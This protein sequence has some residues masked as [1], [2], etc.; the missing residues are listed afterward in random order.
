MVIRRLAQLVQL[1]AVGAFVT[2]AV[3][4]FANEPTLLSA[5]ASAN[6]EVAGESPAGQPIDTDGDG[7]IDTAGD[8]A[9]TESVAVVETVAPIDAAAIF[10]GRCSSCH[11]STGG[12]GIGPQ[13]SGGQVAAAFPD[14]EDQ[15]SVVRDGQGRMPSF[16]NR[17]TDEELRA[18]VRFTRTL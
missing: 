14:I 7:A 6:A 11:G 15:V 17:L 18:V 3:L 5:P 1:I 16:G 8:E 4:L 13:L 10:A 9:T 2:F 12:G